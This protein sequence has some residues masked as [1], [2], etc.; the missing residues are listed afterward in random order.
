MLRVR[1]RGY[2]AQAWMIEVRLET[3]PVMLEGLTVVVDRIE[4]R[5]RSSGYASRVMQGATLAM[6]AAPDMQ[7]LLQQHFGL[8]P[9]PCG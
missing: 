7:W 5:R 8:S 1:A 9:T 3:N 4:T 2:P 6:S